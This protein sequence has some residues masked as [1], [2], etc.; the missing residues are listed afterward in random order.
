M[1]CDW[2]NVACNLTSWEAENMVFLFFPFFLG[3]FTRWPEMS[4]CCTAISKE[5]VWKWCLNWKCYEKVHL[6][7]ISKCQPF[8]AFH[9]RP[10]GSIIN[11]WIIFLSKL[12]KTIK[13]LSKNKPW[14]MFPTIV[15]LAIH[16]PRPILLFAVVAVISCLNCRSKVDKYGNHKDT[17]QWIAYCCSS[18]SFD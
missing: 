2:L 8:W 13:Y 7:I 11:A 18:R 14:G 12:L 5:T 6:R 9:S 3:T 1:Y 4:W 10:H 17:I 15:P 16:G